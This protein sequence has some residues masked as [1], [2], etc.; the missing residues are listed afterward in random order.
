MINQ[1]MFNAYETFAEFNQTD[2]AG[3]FLY[4]AHIWEG[5]IPLVLFGLFSIVTLSTFFS[6]Q[7][8]S[9]KGD[10]FVS[11][12]VAG[13]FTSIVAFSMKLVEGL[14]NT[15]TLITTFIIAIIG[16]VLL[17]VSKSNE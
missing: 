17:F 6:Q 8:L 15:Y 13:F 4:P 16:V 10:F 7:R 5:F 3:L 9:G 12:A 14:I 1:I 11:F 2:L